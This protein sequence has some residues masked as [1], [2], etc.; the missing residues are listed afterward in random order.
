LALGYLHSNNIIYR[1]LKLENILLDEDGYIVVSDFG[2]AKILTDPNQMTETF[3]GTAEYL[4][5][6]VVNSQSYDK[7]V[8][9]WAL[10]ILLYEMIH[11]YTPFFDT[12]QYVTF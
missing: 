7:T 4:A 11:G 8:D 9:W 1:D 6:E 10:G 5:P 12:N 3:C 2:L